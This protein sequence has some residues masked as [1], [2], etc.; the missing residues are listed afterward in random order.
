MMRLWLFSWKTMFPKKLPHYGF[1]TWIKVLSESL[2]MIILV[3]FFCF[4]QAFLFP[5]IWFSL[6]RDCILTKNW[7]Y[8]LRS[9]TWSSCELFLCWKTGLF[10]ES[11]YHICNSFISEICIFKY[12][13]ARNVAITCCY[14][15]CVGICA[16]FVHR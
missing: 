4:K 11:P 15:I 3:S 10:L 9:W 1:Q 8:E 7:N 6:V 12:T 14:T 16:C 13:D 5:Y 2:C